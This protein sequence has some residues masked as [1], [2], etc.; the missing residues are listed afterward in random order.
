MRLGD[1]KGVGV[2]VER[3]VV[4]AALEV[5]MLEMPKATMLEV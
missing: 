1:G 2:V 4:P 3:V 5:V